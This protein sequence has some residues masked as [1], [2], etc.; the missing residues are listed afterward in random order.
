[1]VYLGNRD[2]SLIFEIAPMYAFQTLVDF[3]GYYFPTVVDL[4]VICIKFIH[5]SPF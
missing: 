4:M 5:S 1:M 2:H 3:E